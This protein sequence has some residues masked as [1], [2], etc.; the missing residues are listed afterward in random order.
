[1]NQRTEKV[2]LELSMVRLGATDNWDREFHF[3]AILPG[4]GNMVAELRIN[5]EQLGR[6]LCG[7]GQVPATIILPACKEG[8]Q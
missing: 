2:V 7:G 5:A 3:A 1:M 6:L 4:N 8:D